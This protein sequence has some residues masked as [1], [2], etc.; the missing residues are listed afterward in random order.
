MKKYFAVSFKYSESVFCSNIAHAETV[1]A[2]AAH[3]SRYEW[4]DIREAEAHEV[5]TAR[6]KG[7]PIVEIETTEAATNE[8][9]E[10]TVKEF[11]EIKKAVKEDA[12]QTAENRRFFILNGYMPTWAEEHHGD[13]DRG[14]KQYSTARRWEQ[15]KAG[16]ITR[17]KAVELATKRALKEIEKDTAAKLARL[18]RVAAAPDLTFISISVDWVRSRTWG[19]NPH[20]EARTN[21]GTFSGT[22]SGCGYDKE[23]AAIADALNQCDSVLKALYTLKEEGLRAGLS[24]KSKTAAC[25]RSNGNI[26]GYG[27]GYGAIPYFEGGVGASCFWS[28]LKKCGFSTS[29]HHGKHSDFYSVSKEGA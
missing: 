19:N 10:T 20:A 11:T 16:E 22:A 23:S 24:D 26:C 4:V 28:I 3:Y 8:R 25:G 9:E 17:E 12:E 29:C 6:R 27:A 15:Y 18:D 7:M 2:V 5:E 21:A 14:L 13:L 1:E